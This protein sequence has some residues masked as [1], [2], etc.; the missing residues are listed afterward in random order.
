MGFALMLILFRLFLCH[1]LEYSIPEQCEPKNIV[2]MLKSM[3]VCF[4]N[5]PGKTHLSPKRRVLVCDPCSIVKLVEESILS[6]TY[7]LKFNNHFFNRWC[8]LFIYLIGC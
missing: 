7:L 8:I 2:S 1:S 6:L 3:L 5:E 4:R